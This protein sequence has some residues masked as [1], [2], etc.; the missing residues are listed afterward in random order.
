M[1]S[2][3]INKFDLILD[4][5]VK[6][7]A[8]TGYHGS[9]V[10][11]IAREAGVADGTIYLYFK[12]KEDILVSLFRERLGELV[13]KFKESVQASSTA[14]EALRKICEIHYTE[15]EQNTDLAYVTQIELRQSS[16]EL[17]KAIGQAVKPYIQLIET[18][19][20]KGMEE[21]TFR[22]GLDVKLTRLLIFGA[23]DEA[24]TS[25]LISGRKYSLSGQID[26]TVE[27]FLK[28]LRP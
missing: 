28:A 12:N 9:Q 16:L 27:F 24:V 10:S 1:T 14:D 19:L 13:G 2:K 4:A 20:V 25:W 22:K 18:V 17:R 5:A 6:V 26:P 8:E 3:K 15:L 7:F 23:M 21:G 11:K